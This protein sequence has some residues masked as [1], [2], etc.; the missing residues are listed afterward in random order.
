MID[1]KKPIKLKRT[2]AWRTYTGGS[3]IDALH[4]MDNVNSQSEKQRT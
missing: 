2:G 1:L 4:G 3:L